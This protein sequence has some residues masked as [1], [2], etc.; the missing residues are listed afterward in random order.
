[1]FGCTVVYFQRE[2]E[3]GTMRLELGLY[4]L[5]GIRI[6]LKISESKFEKK[7]T[8]P[9]FI[10]LLSA[11]HFKSSPHVILFVSHT[12]IFPSRTTLRNTWPV[13]VFLK[14]L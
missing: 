4:R 8:V 6:N 14:L 13:W 1:M 5:K 12:Y 3:E 11:E 9:R 10:Y 7:K 2:R